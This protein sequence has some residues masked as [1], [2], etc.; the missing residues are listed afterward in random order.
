MEKRFPCVKKIVI[1]PSFKRFM[2]V[3]A[4]RF[5]ENDFS[6]HPI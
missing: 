3:F 2:G 1:N 6:L 4:D 5:E